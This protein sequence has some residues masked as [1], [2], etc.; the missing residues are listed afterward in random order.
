MKKCIQ[1]GLVILL[2]VACGGEM[3]EP[4][5]E[6]D[7]APKGTWSIS[8]ETQVAAGQVKTVCR[9]AQLPDKPLSVSRT[10]HRGSVGGHHTLLYATSLFPEAVTLDKTFECTDGKHS[11]SVVGGY[12]ASGK[13]TE[14]YWQAPA[15]VT[16]KMPASQVVLL[17]HHAVNTTTEAQDISL[18]VEL[19]LSEDPD[20]IAADVF[21]LL[22][23]SVYLPPMAASTAGVRCPMPT[24][25]SLFALIPHYHE[26]GQRLRAT[27]IDGDDVTPLLTDE[28]SSAEGIH[29]IDPVMKVPAGS[30]IDFECDYLNADPDSVSFGP[31][32]ATDEMCMLLGLYYQES[33]E[34]LPA[35]IKSCDQDDQPYSTGSA[36]CAA[37]LDCLMQLSFSVGGP[38]GEDLDAAEQACFAS[39]CKEAS[40]AARDLGR[41]VEEQCIAECWYGG[42]CS[43]P[44]CPACTGCIEAKCDAADTACQAASCQ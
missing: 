43:E 10:S 17:E 9:Y 34:A 5:A 36:S 29:L 19:E 40:F 6:P 11:L 37:G 32:T 18:T 1:A 13:S 38:T 26:H 23:H 21:Y 31:H 24:E 35:A 12:Y 7:P 3:T 8:L 33:G 14:S 44:F 39:M 16:V 2:C 20:T 30:F 15:G 27:L 25:I 42:L 4:P 28:D 41:C 22:N